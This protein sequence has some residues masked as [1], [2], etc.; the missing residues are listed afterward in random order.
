[1]PA[2]NRAFWEQKF[3]RTVERDAEQLRLLKSAGWQALIVWECELRDTA[4][5]S[6]RIRSF[7]DRAEV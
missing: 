7:L 2:E 5:L 6:K 3:K 1:M 4:S